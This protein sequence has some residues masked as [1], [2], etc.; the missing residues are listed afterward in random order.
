[1]AGHRWHPQC[2]R[3]EGLVRPV[4]LDPTGRGGPTRGQAR[5]T[6]WRRTSRGWYVPA[7]VP[8]C[9]EQR[10]LEQ[11]VRLPSCGAITAWASLRWRGATFFDGRGRDGRDLPVPLVLGGWADLGRDELVVVSRERFWPSQIE[12]V[13]GVPCACAER[14]VFDEMRRVGGLRSGVVVTEMAIAARL[15][16]LDRMWAYVSGCNGWTGVPMVRKSLLLVSEDSKSPPE[17]LM[18]LNWELDAG[19]PRPLCNK[20]VFDLAGNLLG[21]PDLFDP[22]AGVVGE[23]D[24]AD[25]LEHDR[26]R[27]DAAREQRFRDHGLEYFELV[28]GDLAHPGLV[29]Q[30][31]QSTRRRAR[32]L[33]PDQRTWTLEPPPWWR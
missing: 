18:R 4:P 16:T 25:H 32:F 27:H 12:A 30:R 7:D 20:P 22:V 31:M 8:D 29:V 9:V 13:A 28:R 14:S 19:F 5:G 17:T 26:R 23:Y 6:R 24:G 33:P 21:Y 11:A 10:I 3:P 2:S 15:T 1:M